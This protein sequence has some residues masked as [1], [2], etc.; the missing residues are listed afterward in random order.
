[1]GY[2]YRCKNTKNLYPSFQNSNQFNS[3]FSFY[4]LLLFKNYAYF[5]DQI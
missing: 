5:K 2:S 1:M 3:V 4:F